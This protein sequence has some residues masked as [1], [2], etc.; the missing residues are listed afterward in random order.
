MKERSI[1]SRER[2]KGRSPLWSPEATPLVAPV[3]AKS[4]INTRKQY[5]NVTNSIAK[6][7]SRGSKTLWQVQGSALLGLGAKPLVSPLA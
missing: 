6:R 7:E 5:E 4:R 1:Q 2:V 3:G